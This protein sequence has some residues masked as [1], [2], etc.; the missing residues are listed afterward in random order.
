MRAA[1]G[2]LLLV[3]GPLLA[4]SV[5]D[6]RIP[7]GYRPPVN[8]AEAGLWEEARRLESALQESPLLVRDAAVNDYVRGVVCRVAG[9]YCADVRVYV[10]RN[11]GFN[12]S[13]APNGMLVVWSGT[14]TRLRDADELAVLV[15]HE[16]AHY[17]LTHAYN[18]FKLANRAAPPLQVLALVPWYG[19]AAT[20]TGALAAASYSAEQEEDADLMGAELAR[21]AGFSADAA[22]TLWESLAQETLTVR[23]GD[24]SLAFLGFHPRVEQ[25]LRRLRGWRSEVPGAAA[26]RAAD[27]GL[28]AAL[29]AEYAAMLKD[30]VDAN[31][32]TQTLML[33]ERHA[34]LG[35]RPG[36]VAYFRAEALR[37][38]GSP[39]DLDAA[40]R[41]YAKAMADPEPVPQAY[42]N[43][44]YLQREAGLVAEADSNLRRYLELLPEAPDAPLVRSALRSP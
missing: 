42:R 31:R 21:R 37:Q 35:V 9:P 4:E 18:D 13:M 33:L 11:P 22:I 1:I 25:R 43:L 15:G 41:E 7:P 19:I 26:D 24:T 39:Q 3:S 28:L 2:L 12:A 16:L 20:L 8:S 32:P 17:Q 5:P 38:Q 30:Q 36:L 10:V 27:K 40:R 34:A 44:A 6:A 14:L 23:E 29:E